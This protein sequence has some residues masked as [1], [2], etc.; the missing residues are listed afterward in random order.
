MSKFSDPRRGDGLR[1]GL[2]ALLQM[3]TQHHRSRVLPCRDDLS[4]GGILGGDHEGRCDAQ[5]GAATIPFTCAD[6]GRLSLGVAAC[7]PSADFAGP[8]KIVLAAY[9]GRTPP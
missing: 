8:M 9:G 2:A 3:P 5:V 7:R 1:D 6:R 4:D